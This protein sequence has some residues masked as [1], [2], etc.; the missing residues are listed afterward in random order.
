MNVY[1][2]WHDEKHFW[3]CLQCPA[4]ITEATDSMSSCF[5]CFDETTLSI[6]GNGTIECYC[7]NGYVMSQ[8]GKTCEP[9]CSGGQYL[10]LFGSCQN[11][12][13]L[14]LIGPPFLHFRVGYRATHTEEWPYTDSLGKLL[15]IALVSYW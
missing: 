1:V 10:N 6:D 13:T 4:T 7:R 9:L 2:F 3:D 15:Y 11:V 8:D 12:R 5:D 14:H